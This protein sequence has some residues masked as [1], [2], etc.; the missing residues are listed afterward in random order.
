MLVYTVHSSRCLLLANTTPP[1]AHSSSSFLSASRD[2]LALHTQHAQV[3]AREA[4]ERLMTQARE[5]LAKLVSRWT[6]WTF[7]RV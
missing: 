5:E 6:F 4:G 3:T 2:K 1:L 7:K